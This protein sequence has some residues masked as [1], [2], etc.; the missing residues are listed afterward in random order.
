MNLNVYILIMEQVTKKE[1][2]R[3]QI[4]SLT[5]KS[6]YLIK[7]ILQIFLFFKKILQY[8]YKYLWFNPR[9]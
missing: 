1:H 5:C 4:L 2:H 7:P 9:K 6:C 8:F 3:K